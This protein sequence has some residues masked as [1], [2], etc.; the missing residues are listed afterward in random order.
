MDDGRGKEDERADDHE[1]GEDDPLGVGITLSHIAS[2]LN[3]IA[4]HSWS[5]FFPPLKPSIC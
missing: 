4:G 3:C 1:D 2:G 5:P